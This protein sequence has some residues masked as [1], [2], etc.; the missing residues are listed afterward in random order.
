MHF[1]QREQQAL[2]D[3]GVE[4]ATIEAASDAVV[5]AT[6]DAAG[7]LEAFFDGRETVYSDMDIAHSSSEIQ[8]HTV[9]YCD[10]FTHADDIRGYLRFDTWGVPVEGGRILSEEKVELSLGPTVHGRVRFAADEDA[11]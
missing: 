11:L 10:L 8:E 3:A 7:E 9:E 4:Q 6:D 5:E 1:T 2:R